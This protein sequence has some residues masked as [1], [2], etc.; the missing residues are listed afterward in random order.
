MANAARGDYLIAKALLAVG[1]PEAALDWADRCLQTCR[2]HG[3]VDF[4]LA[5]ALEIRARSLRALDRTEEARGRLGGGAGR[6]DRRSRGRG[7]VRP[8][9]QG[10][11]RAH[12]CSRSSVALIAFALLRL[13]PITVRN[14]G[15]R[16]PVVSNCSVT[17]VCCSSTGSSR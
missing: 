16:D 1:R 3:L 11:S 10:R 2:D 7:V 13:A 15:A 6:T 4:D 12:R 9:R 5:Y 8:R 14:S 17:R